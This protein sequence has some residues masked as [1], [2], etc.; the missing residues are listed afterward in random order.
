MSNGAEC[1]ILQVCCPDE[2]KAEAALTQRLVEQG[3]PPAVAVRCATYLLREFDF[4]PKGT[5]APLIAQIAAL[6]R[7]HPLP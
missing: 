6:A 4:A 3:C 7:A 5:V 2:A 1:C